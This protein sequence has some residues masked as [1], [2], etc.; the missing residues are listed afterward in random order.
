MLHYNNYELLII[1]WN[2]FSLFGQVAGIALTLKP[3]LDSSS[4]RAIVAH[5][6]Q[7]LTWNQ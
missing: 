3:Q 6:D 2:V 4:R 7:F 1:G 5:P